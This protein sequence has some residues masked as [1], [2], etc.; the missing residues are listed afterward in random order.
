MHKRAHSTEI[1]NRPGI[2]V[3]RGLYLRNDKLMITGVADV[4]EFIR[5]KD[6]IGG[7]N[8][9]G[10]EGRWIP[11]PVEY[12]HGRPKKD[13][14][15]KIQLCA[16]AVC[17][18]EMLGC[19]INEGEL[20]YGRTRRREN[21]KFTSALRKELQKTCEFAH[22]LLAEGEL[23]PA[24]I[25]SACKSCSLENICLPQLDQSVYK[26]IKDY[27]KEVENETSS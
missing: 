21:V 16:Q 24:K 15:D 18:E 7:V 6:D 12:K 5:D 26:Y 4:V 20:F 22:K 1:E 8:L 9:E 3:A 2:H 13:N 23:P 25:S 10:Y 14:C 19:K 27:L 17:L 11:H